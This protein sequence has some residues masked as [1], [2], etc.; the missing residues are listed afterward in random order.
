MAAPV[1]AC[2]HA[3]PQDDFKRACLPPAAD[4][5]LEIAITIILVLF[6]LE[7]SECL[8][9]RWRPSGLG[10]HAARMAWGPSPYTPFPRRQ[11][12]TAKQRLPII[13]YPTSMMHDASC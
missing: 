4:L 3:W 9:R 2:M 13:M 6:V 12:P 5:G 11:P 7:M 1:H 8:R 10:I